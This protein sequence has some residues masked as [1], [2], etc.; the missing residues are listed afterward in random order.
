M[1]ISES[2]RGVAWQNSTSPMPPTC[3]RRVSGH[4]SIA[5]AFVSLSCAAFQA[6]A[7]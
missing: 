1:K 5:F 7:S 2:L 3:S 4:L 6:I